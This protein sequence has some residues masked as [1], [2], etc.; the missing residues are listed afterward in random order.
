MPSADACTNI[1]RMGQNN[2]LLTGAIN[3]GANNGSPVE[4]S[5][6]SKDRGEWYPND[7]Q[8]TRAME[9]TWASTKIWINTILEGEVSQTLRHNAMARVAAMMQTTHAHMFE[10]F[11]AGSMNLKADADARIHRVNPFARASDPVEFEGWTGSL[12]ALINREDLSDDQLAEMVSNLVAVIYTDVWLSRPNTN[13]DLFLYDAMCIRA[14]LTARADYIA[15]SKWSPYTI[16]GEMK[17]P[18]ALVDVARAGMTTA[19]TTLT[20]Q[21]NTV[22]IAFDAVASGLMAVAE[23]PVS[24][25]LKLLFPYNSFIARNDAD[26]INPVAIVGLGA[27]VFESNKTAEMADLMRKLSTIESY[28]TRVCSV[29]AAVSGGKRVAF[30]AVHWHANVSM[31]NVALCVLGLINHS[32]EDQGIECAYVSGDFNYQSVA[33]ADTVKTILSE[34]GV[35]SNVVSADGRSIITKEATRTAMQCQNRKVGVCVAAPRIVEYSCTK[36]GGTI[37]VLGSVVVNGGVRQTPSAAW[38]Y[39]HGGVLVASEFP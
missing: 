9:Q 32:L 3:C 2:S 34:F 19:L 7:L 36:R 23:A 24:A 26:P 5:P 13:V 28:R 6:P 25:G 20:E 12:F 30:T 33:D 17:T 8:V 10:A 37:N 15:L 27:A 31:D 11:M 35:T 39:D 18:A 1:Q 29:T 16:D 21:T 38:P 22:A 14:M 4:Y